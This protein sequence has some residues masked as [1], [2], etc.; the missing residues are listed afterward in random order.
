[1]EKRHRVIVHQAY[2]LQVVRLG[3]GPSAVLQ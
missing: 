1:M 3:I 2:R